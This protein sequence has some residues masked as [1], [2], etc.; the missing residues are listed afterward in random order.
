MEKIKSKKWL[1]VAVV[2]ILSLTVLMLAG[3]GGNGLKW[4]S[5]I[6]KTTYYI[7]EKIDLSNAVVTYENEE[8]ELVDVHLILSNI[9]DFSTD[10]F[11]NRTATVTVGDKS[12]SFNYT[13]KN[14]RLGSYQ[15]EDK[16]TAGQVEDISSLRLQFE[17]DGTVIFN[18]NGAETSYFFEVFDDGTLVITGEE[19]VYYGYYQNNTLKLF[20]SQNIEASESV[21]TFVIA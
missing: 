21:L 4:K 8:G 3:C 6:P 13:V 11:G 12:L 17:E 7:G 15:G 19:I 18:E 10:T 14:L 2:A 1:I 16:V 9:K 20:T 5:A